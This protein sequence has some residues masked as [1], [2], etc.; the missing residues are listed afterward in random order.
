MKDETITVHA[1]KTR[2][3]QLLHRVEAGET[4]VIARGKTPVAKLIPINP[5]ARRQFGALKG[6]IELGPEFFE[7][8]PP[9]ELKAW[10]S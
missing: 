5:P 1:A 8:L 6:K 2:L 4:I 3:S 9:D 7:P 10:E